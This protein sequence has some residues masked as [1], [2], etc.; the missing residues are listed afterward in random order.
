VQLIYK[1]AIS[2]MQPDNPLPLGGKSAE[3]SEGK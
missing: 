1:H 3:G 2:T